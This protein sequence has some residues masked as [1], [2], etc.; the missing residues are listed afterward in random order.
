MD[1][2]L[3]SDI[4]FFIT[5]IAVIVIASAILVALIYVVRILADLRAVSKRLSDG[6]RF[7]AEDIDALRRAVKEEGMR[8]RHFF[9][10]SRRVY[11]KSR[12][13]RALRRNSKK[14]SV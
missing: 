2:L 3:K 5:G 9:D 4:F 11:T 6:S 10:F 1:A 12:T 13:H 7:I 14:N 8:L